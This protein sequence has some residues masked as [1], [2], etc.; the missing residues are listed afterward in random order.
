[1]K[2]DKGDEDMHIEVNRFNLVMSVAY[3]LEISTFF[4]MPPPDY[5]PD[6]G[7]GGGVGDV[8]AGTSGGGG[9]TSV[10]GERESIVVPDGDEGD[11]KETR[12]TIYVKVDTPDIFLVE[13]I[14]DVNT[15][16]LMLNTALQINYWQVKLDVRD[17]LVSRSFSSKRIPKLPLFHRCLRVRCH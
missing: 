13:N 2:T 8:G 16:A 5:I 15:D 11:V 14:E 3:L 12:R 10:A 17:F 9:G 6:G 7:G 1:M 4:S